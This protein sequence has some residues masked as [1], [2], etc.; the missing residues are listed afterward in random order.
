MHPI[1]EYNHS[2]IIHAQMINQRTMYSPTKLK[3]Y[4]LF[5]IKPSIKDIVPPVVA[6]LLHL[7]VFYHAV[8]NYL[9]C[10]PHLNPTTSSDEFYLKIYLLERAVFLAYTFDLVCC[11]L[12]KIVPFSRCNSPKDIA[13]H[14]LPILLGV[15]PLCIPTW[16]S[17]LRNADPLIHDILNYT[18]SDSGG[19]WRYAMMNGILQA[20]GWGFLSSLNEFIMC[21]Q[22]AEMNWYGIELFTQLNSYPGRIKVMTSRC[23][24]GIELYFKFGIFCIFSCFGFRAICALDQ[25]WYGYLTEINGNGVNDLYM[26]WKVVQKIVASPFFIRTVFFRVFM[27]SMY[28]TMGW[29]TFKKIQKF[30]LE[31]SPCKKNAD[32]EIRMGEC[33]HERKIQ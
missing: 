27:L 17:E 32:G 2:N 18:A 11:Y 13:S 14:H 23:V 24:I 31:R 15:L 20:T 21:L 30:H 28:P 8:V 25:V 22:R 3:Q 10:L 26:S 1:S 33:K 19:K 4:L 7:H 29:R 9:L 16:A 12:F 6:S 5:H